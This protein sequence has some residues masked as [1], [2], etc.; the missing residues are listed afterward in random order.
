MRK[1][2]R[3]ADSNH[4]SKGGRMPSTRTFLF[5]NGQQK[6][7]IR[8]T[9]CKQR[10]L[11]RTC[12]EF[13]KICRRRNKTPLVSGLIAYIREHLPKADAFPVEVHV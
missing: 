12:Q 9:Y 10:K 4:F 5:D 13:M 11:T 1:M 2:A 8:A 6:F 7:E 3:T